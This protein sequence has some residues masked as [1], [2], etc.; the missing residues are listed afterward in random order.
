MFGFAFSD[1]PIH[2]FK[3]IVEISKIRYLKSIV[4]PKPKNEI[5]YT[6]KV[7]N[8]NHIPGMSVHILYLLFSYFA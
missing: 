5:A 1:F 6:L 7:S 8:K 2:V 3:K 4:L